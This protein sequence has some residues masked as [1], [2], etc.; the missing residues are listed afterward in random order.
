MSTLFAPVALTFYMVSTSS[1]QKTSSFS[2]FQITAY[3]YEVV[4]HSGSD[5]HFPNAHFYA[6]CIHK[7]PVS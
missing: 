3:D 2:A 4:A 1:F 6:I 5:L 7:K